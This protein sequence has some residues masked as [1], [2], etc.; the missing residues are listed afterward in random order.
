MTI[1]TLFVVISAAAVVWM[2]RPRESDSRIGIAD[3]PALA[4]D[5]PDDQWLDYATLQ[6]MRHNAVGSPASDHAVQV[7]RA[8]CHKWRVPDA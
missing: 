3:V 1:L 8:Y 7:R 6:Y 4:D 5:A 2:S